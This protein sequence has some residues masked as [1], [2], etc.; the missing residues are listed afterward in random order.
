M[1]LGYGLLSGG[2]GGKEGVDSKRKKKKGE[3]YIYHCA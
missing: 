3:R 1:G 2:R